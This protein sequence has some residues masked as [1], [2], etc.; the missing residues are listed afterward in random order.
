M[1]RVTLTLA[2]GRA[3]AITKADKDNKMA[4]RM[5]IRASQPYVTLTIY[6]HVTSY[7]RSGELSTLESAL[8][9]LA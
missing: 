8:S 3:V 7:G 5:R 2:A 9:A 4:I 1:A 6:G